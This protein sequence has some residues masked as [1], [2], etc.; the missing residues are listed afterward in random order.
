MS[1]ANTRL[2]VEVCPI[3]FFQVSEPARCATSIWGA[4]GMQN[5]PPRL[6]E[7]G[8]FGH[9]FLILRGPFDR[10][11]SRS[12]RGRHGDPGDALV[13]PFL[14]RVNVLFCLSCVQLVIVVVSVAEHKSP[15][16]LTTTPGWTDVK[17][18]SCATGEFDYLKSDR[19]SRDSRGSGAME[20]RKQQHRISHLFSSFS[21]L[22]LPAIN[23][24]CIGT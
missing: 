1:V 10:G 4:L 15:V 11:F 14:E 5:L 8:Q 21:T 20:E 2:G 9:K 19:K 18:V 6:V 16:H 13:R 22:S 23:V 17:V 3:E 24:A 12:R 7:G